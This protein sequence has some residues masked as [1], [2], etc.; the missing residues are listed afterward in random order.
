MRF[1]F[2]IVEP[3]V[4]AGDDRIFIFFYSRNLIDVVITLIFQKASGNVRS[5]L[6]TDS[7]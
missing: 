7:I 6:S 1:Y 4:L 3:L 2:N 5:Q